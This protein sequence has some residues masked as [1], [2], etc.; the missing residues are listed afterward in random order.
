MNALVND[1]LGRLRLLLGDP[2]VTAQFDAWAGRPARFARYTSR[3]LYPGVRTRREGPAAP[4]VASRTSTSTPRPRPRTR[5]LA[6]PRRSQGT[7]REAEG[8]RQVAGEA[9]HSRLV[10][11]SRTALAGHETGEFQRAVMLPERPRTADAPRG[12]RGT[13]GRPHHQLLDVGVHADAAAGA[14]DLRLPPASGSPTTRTSVPAHRRRGAPLPRMPPAP[15]W[16]C[17]CAVCGR[18]SG[19]TPDRLQ[20]ITTSAS[21]SDAEY[22]REFA[23]QLSGKEVDDFRTI[24]GQAQ[25]TGRPPARAPRQTR[26]C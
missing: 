26:R 25:A 22:A 8:P 20:V 5:R 16:R 7:H 11:A 24:D 19:I 14:A 21:F 13:A 4:Q 6:S 9:G 10:R 23:A 3:T 1:Q 12:A 18:D 2:R 15:R 17:C